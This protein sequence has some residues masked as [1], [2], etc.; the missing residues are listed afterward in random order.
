MIELAAA[1][2][3]EMPAYVLERITHLLNERQRPLKNASI[4]LLG[5]TYKKDVNDIRESPALDV[6]Q[7]LLKEGAKVSY[8]DPFVPVLGR[9]ASQKLT[10]AFLKKQDCVVILTNHSSFPYP[11]VARYARL[12]FDTRNAMRPFRAGSH[13]HFL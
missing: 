3:E 8:S 9:S 4:L 13:V 10:P 6:M 1:I 12:V 11:L 5:V 7:G 2:N